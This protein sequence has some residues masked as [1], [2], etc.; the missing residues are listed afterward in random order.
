MDA[1]GPFLGT[2]FVY[3]KYFT[4]A[5]FNSASVEMSTCAIRSCSCANSQIDQYFKI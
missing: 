4:I 3:F 1:D 5:A 2:E